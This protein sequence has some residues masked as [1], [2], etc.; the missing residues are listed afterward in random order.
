MGTRTRRI[1]RA[2]ALCFLVGL[3]YGAA[4][5][6]VENEGHH[7]NFEIVLFQPVTKYVQHPLKARLNILSLA[8]S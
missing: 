6:R 8:L 1:N 2:A 4:I 3:T 7:A 5:L